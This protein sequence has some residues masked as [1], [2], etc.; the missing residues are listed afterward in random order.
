MQIME[1][2]FDR[3]QVMRAMRAAYNNP[4]RA[5]EYLMTGIPESANVP[6]APRVRYSPCIRMI[7]HIFSERL[8]GISDVHGHH[9]QAVSC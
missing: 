6:A 8:K 1:M 5:V 7:F 4:D 2:G 3:E 9:T